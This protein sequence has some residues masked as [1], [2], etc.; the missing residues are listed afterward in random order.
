MKKQILKP[1]ILFAI[2]I[3][4]LDACQKDTETAPNTTSD[5]DKF[6]GT[7]ITTSNGTSGTLNF[8][9]SIAAG[10]SS[11]SQVKISNFDNEGSGTTVFGDVSGNN[12]SLTQTVIA[13]DTITGSGT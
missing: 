10:N 2:M 12:L 1:V 4:V 9:M 5:R 11:A 8:T 13:S 3:V 6:L 7:W